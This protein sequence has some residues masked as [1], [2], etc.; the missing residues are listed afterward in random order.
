MMGGKSEGKK[1]KHKPNS[2]VEKRKWQ[3]ERK[4]KRNP[5][6]KGKGIMRR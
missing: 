3:Q 2:K 1:G 4:K 6:R 5:G